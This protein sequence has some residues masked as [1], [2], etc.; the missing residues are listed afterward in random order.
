PCPASGTR[1]CPGGG[2]SYISAT[3]RAA[4]SP[5]EA[6]ID[7]VLVEM[8]DLVG[9]FEPHDVDD[10]EGEREADAEDPGEIPH[11]AFLLVVSALADRAL[12]DRT[13]HHAIGPAG[14]RDH[15]RQEQDHDP[16]HDL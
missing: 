7:I 9:R 13:A 14:I 3:I 12:G 5:A 1:S 10:A 2:L 8:A 4:F 6:V 15:D 11:A 16:E